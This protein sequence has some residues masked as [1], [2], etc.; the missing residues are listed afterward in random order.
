MMMRNLIN[1]LK[2]THPFVIYRCTIATTTVATM[3]YFAKEGLDSERYS[4]PNHYKKYTFNQK[5]KVAV[6]GALNGAGIG[7]CIGILSPVIVVLAP[8]TLAVSAL[9]CVLDKQDNDAE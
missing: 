8:P 3:G 9:V 5:L 2:D 6:R 1:K 4:Y 7:V